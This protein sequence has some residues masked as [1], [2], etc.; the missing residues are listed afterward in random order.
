[1]ATRAWE[2]T[3][4]RCGRCCYEKVEFEGEIY[5]TDTPCEML[6]LETRLCRVY[7]QREQVRRG[8]VALTPRLVRKGFLPCDCPYVAELADYQA[9]R[10]WAAEEEK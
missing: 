10:L 1:M 7:A 4:R 2:S 3:C 9:P 5:F 8:C 6:D